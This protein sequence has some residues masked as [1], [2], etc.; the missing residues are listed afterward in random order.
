MADG[1]LTLTEF[2]ERSGQAHAATQRSELVDLLDDLVDE[3]A[4]CS[5]D[6]ARA[7]RLRTARRVT[8]SGLLTKLRTPNATVKWYLRGRGRW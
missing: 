7:L 5:L 3:P 2:D 1:Q 6:L 8:R 4:G